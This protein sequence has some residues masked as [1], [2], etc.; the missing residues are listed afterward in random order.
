[1]KTIEKTMSVTEARKRMFD[2][3]ERVQTPGVYFTL[4]ERGRSRAVIMSAE[5]FTSW[6]E[7]ID[8]LTEFPD[9]KKD[10]ARAEVEARRGE[11]VSLE[12]IKRLYAVPRRTLKGGA[13]KSR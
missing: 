3:T 5:E 6:A 8:I 12:E 9:I 1:M 11:T 4:T 13:K 10:L 2:L 7:T